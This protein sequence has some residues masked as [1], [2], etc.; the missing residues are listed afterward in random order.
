MPLSFPLSERWAS[1]GS[2]GT[3]RTA[4]MMSSG[5]SSSSDSDGVEAWDERRAQMEAEGLA[6]AAMME[7]GVGMQEMGMEEAKDEKAAAQGEPP[8]QHRRHH[9]K[10][11]LDDEDGGPRPRG[12]CGWLRR[13]RTRKEWAL[14]IGGVTLG[15]AAL[16]AC[17]F[18]ATY[19][20]ILRTIDPPALFITQCRLVDLAFAGPNVNAVIGV[21]GAIQVNALSLC[22]GRLWVV[23]HLLLPAPSHPHPNQPKP[24]T[25]KPEPLPLPR[26]DRLAQNPRLV[27]KFR[28]RRAD[29]RRPAPLP[30]PGAPRARD[31]RGE[32][33]LLRCEPRR[34]WGA[35]QGG[36][37]CVRV[38]VE[39]GGVSG[40]C[41][42]RRRRWS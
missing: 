15:L 28:D 32:F 16:G 42:W 37:W 27:P 3:V 13:R 23:V 21:E 25:Y 35:G 10:K 29:R 2:G 18:L 1:F 9:K 34:G 39:F 6:A 12:F 11:T 38:G 7:G 8:T 19:A 26:V 17:I 30:D 33:V 20:I 41:W 24:P 22:V 14:L 40:W 5:G 36:A 4:S 31:A